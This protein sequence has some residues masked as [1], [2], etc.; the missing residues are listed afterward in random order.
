MTDPSRAREIETTMPPIRF[1]IFF[2]VITGLSA[3]IHYYL[4]ARLVRDPAWDLAVR[5]P[6]TLFFHRRLNHSEIVRAVGSRLVVERSDDTSLNQHKGTGQLE[7]I[8]VHEAERMPVHEQ[9]HPAEP[10]IQAKELP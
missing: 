5:R 6:L 10:D 1:L 9:R 4:W 3:L 2:V 8:A 7:T